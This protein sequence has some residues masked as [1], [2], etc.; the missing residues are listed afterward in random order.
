MATIQT[1]MLVKSDSAPFLNVA[2][3]TIRV[4]TRVEGK[5]YQTVSD[6]PKT[7]Q[8]YSEDHVKVLGLSKLS[9]GDL[10]YTPSNIAVDWY[11]VPAGSPVKITAINVED[12]VIDVIDTTLKEHTYI[13]S[14]LFIPVKYAIDAGYD[15]INPNLFTLSADTFKAALHKLYGK[16]ASANNVEVTPLAID[17]S[18]HYLATRVGSKVSVLKIKREDMNLEQFK[19]TGL[20]DSLEAMST[21]TKIKF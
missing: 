4:M 5:T 20:F 14:K 11:T 3:L 7:I 13:N 2:P 12:G 16:Y 6:E 15:D 21:I 1:R 19:W 17:V 8:D 10:G 9:V 18:Q